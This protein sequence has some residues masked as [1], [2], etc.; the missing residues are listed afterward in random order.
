VQECIY[1]ACSESSSLCNEV[2]CKSGAGYSLL[3]LH[4]QESI[5]AQNHTAPMLQSIEIFPSVLSNAALV[6]SNRGTRGSV[7]VKDCPTSR[8][9]A[10][11][12]SDAA[13]ELLQFT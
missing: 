13:N 11:S 9:V 7:L 8:N 2:E 3:P 5:P 12:R 4:R 1:S 6:P 10:G